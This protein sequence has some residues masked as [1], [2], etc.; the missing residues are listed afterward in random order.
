VFEQW[1]LQSRYQWTLDITVM[2]ARYGIEEF[3]D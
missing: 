1:A 2:R 3:D